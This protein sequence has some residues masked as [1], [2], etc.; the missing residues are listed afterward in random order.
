MERERVTA[1]ELIRMKAAGRRIAMLTAYDY[2]FARLLDEAGVD[3]LLVGDSLGMVVLG[4]P[5]TLPVTVDHM[6]HHSAAVVRGTR[7]AMVV[8]D[9]PFMSYQPGPVAALHSAGRLLKEAGVQAVKLEGGRSVLPQVRALV[10]AGIPVMGHLGMTPQSVHQFGGYRVQARDDQA[11]ER[12][13]EDALEL[14][15]AGVFSLVLECIPSELAR[16]VTRELRVPTIGI[17]AGPACD[18]QVLVTQDLLGMFPELAPRFVKHYAELGA[19]VVAAAQTFCQE[20][21]QGAFPEERHSYGGR[22]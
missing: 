14:Q 17:G 9:M 5:T 4:F 6:V 2:T 15:E 11:A 20:V 10:E 3:V 8:A 22:P 1:P 12:L 21:R 7:R 18:G 19:A 13:L 16:R